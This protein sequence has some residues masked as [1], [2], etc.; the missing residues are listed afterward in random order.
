[1]KRLHD[2]RKMMREYNDFAPQVR[3]L[4]A[5]TPQTTLTKV[6][7]AVQDVPRKRAVRELNRLS[8]DQDPPP[9][10]MSAS[11]CRFSTKRSTISSSSSRV[12]RAS[13][14]GCFPTSGPTTTRSAPTSNSDASKSWGTRFTGWS[15][16]LPL[17]G[18]A[19]VQ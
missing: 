2:D 14:R 9:S 15:V 12:Y 4:T 16:S 1:M 10:R 13:S 11:R 17:E 7:P 8:T 19:G 3:S 6:C 18:H 5:C